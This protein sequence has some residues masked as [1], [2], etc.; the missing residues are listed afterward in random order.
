M[1][2]EQIKTTIEA[3]DSARYADMKNLSDEE[4][5]HFHNMAIHWGEWTG[6]EL[7]ARNTERISRSKY[8]GK[9]HRAPSGQWAWIIFDG[10][11]EVV[12]GNG[13]ESEGEALEAMHN[14]LSSYTARS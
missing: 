3:L 12:R 10:A 8:T 9:V 2:K 4:L 13:Y 11:E 5:R 1:S 7:K 14:E 6:E